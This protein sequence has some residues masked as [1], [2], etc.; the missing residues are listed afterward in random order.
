MDWGEII[1][2]R[3]VLINRRVNGVVENYG[4]VCLLFLFVFL[5]LVDLYWYECGWNYVDGFYL[6]GGV[7]YVK[8]VVGIF[9][10]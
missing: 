9:N 5:L 8:C 2:Y 7:I 1:V 4:L 10:I 6:I 3:Y